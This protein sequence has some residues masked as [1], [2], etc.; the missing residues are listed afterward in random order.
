MPNGVLIIAETR[1]GKIRGVSAEA[2]SLGRRLA[3]ERA[4]PCHAVLIGGGITEQAAGL[5]AYGVET[6]YV[7][8]H[9]AL[10]TYAGTTW[11][12]AVRQAVQECDPA[13]IVLAA[14]STGKD[15]GPRVA[16]AL[17]AGYAA[18]C[19]E[20]AVEDGHLVATRPV[21]AGKAFQTVRVTTPVAVASLRPKNFAVDAS[22]GGSPE[23]ETLDVAWAGEVQGEQARPVAAAE[24]GRIDLTEADRIVSGGRGMGGPQNWA[25]LEG[26]AE[27]LDAELGA[28]RAVVDA[29]WR[30]HAEQVGQTGKTVTPEL[31]VACGISGAMQ[32]LAGMSRSKVIV[33]VNKDPDAPIFGVADYGIVGD[34]NDV[35]PALAE[36]VRKVAGD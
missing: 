2:A 1:D 11:L 9:D 6:V 34:V 33:A 35:L 27:V 19:T 36:E 17:G 26:L 12:R 20:V 30:P 7:A 22:R 31:Y 4:A 16:A 15:L 29:G 24:G 23:V 18:A 8:D 3:E 13:V 5:G 10:R 25:I 32:H 14:T 21:Y 28:S